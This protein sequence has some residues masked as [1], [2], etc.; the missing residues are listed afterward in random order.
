MKAFVVA[1]QEIMFEE[2]NYEGKD[3][4][5]IPQSLEYQE[6]QRIRGL[7]SFCYKIKLIEKGPCLGRTQLFILCD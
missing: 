7:I 5:I 3:Y 6:Q 1:G 4:L 2:L